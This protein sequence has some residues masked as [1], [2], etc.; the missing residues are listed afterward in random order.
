M[1][2]L[3]VY[4]VPSKMH[5]LVLFAGFCRSV[6]DWSLYNAFMLTPDVTSK[7]MILDLLQLTVNN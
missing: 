1:N 6:A 4:W 2:T 5:M 3:G 7:E